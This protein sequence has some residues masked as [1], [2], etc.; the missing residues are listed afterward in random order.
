V[1]QEEV[2]AI[3][4]HLGM[5]VVALDP[6]RPESKGQVERTISYLE[7]SFMALRS[8]DSLA[9]LRAQS[10]AWA[11]D[12]AVRRHHRWVGARVSKAWLVERGYLRALPDPLP[13]VDRRSEIRVTKDGFVRVG[14]VDYSCLQTWR[15]GACR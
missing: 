1:L 15:A 9:D 14:D 4:G 8:F 5:K 11:A 12:V 10:D 6:R 3:G 13:D 7:S 2:V